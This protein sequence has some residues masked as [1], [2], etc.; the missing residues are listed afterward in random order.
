[1]EPI[2]LADNAP[3]K[4]PIIEIIIVADVNKRIVLGSFSK[5]MSLTSEDPKSRFLAHNKV[6]RALAPRLLHCPPPR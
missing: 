2:L 3:T 1:M 6:S 5:I 4:I